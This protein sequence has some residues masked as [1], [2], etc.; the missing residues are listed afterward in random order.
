VITYFL[1]VLICLLLVLIPVVGG[2]Y[3][4]WKR[5][6]ITGV[7]VFSV[8]AFLAAAWIVAKLGGI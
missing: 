6:Q 7:D 4:M 3:S 5:Q 1:T 8:L 2:G